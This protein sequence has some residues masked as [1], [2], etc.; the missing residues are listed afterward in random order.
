MSLKTPLMASVGFCS[1]FYHLSI[2]IGAAHLAVLYAMWVLW[3]SD[4]FL[5]I[6]G[7]STT[8]SSLSVRL[9]PQ[10]MRSDGV[11]PDVALNFTKAVDVTW[12]HRNQR[13]M[14]RSQRV[15]IDLRRWLESFL[16]DVYAG[17]RTRRIGSARFIA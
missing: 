3:F 5:D 14:T 17:G 13:P 8:V 7:L 2:S 4:R 9:A 1:D 16:S 15:P 6:K 11:H 12:D 10:C